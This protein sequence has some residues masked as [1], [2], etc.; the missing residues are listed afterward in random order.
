MLTISI[1]A[2]EKK[3]HFHNP[4][5]PSPIKKKKPH[6]NPTNILKKKASMTT[7]SGETQECAGRELMRDTACLIFIQANTIT[8][9]FKGQVAVNE[10]MLFGE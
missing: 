4:S 1:K 2:R 7:R 10:V 5:T 3:K 6:R 9:V 8:N